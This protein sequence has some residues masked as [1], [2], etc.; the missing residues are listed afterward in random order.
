MESIRQNLERSN[1][2]VLLAKVAIQFPRVASFSLSVSISYLAVSEV[3]LID[4]VE[5]ENIDEIADE[6]ACSVEAI[7][8]LDSPSTWNAFN[9]PY[10]RGFDLDVSFTKLKALIENAKADKKPIEGIEVFNLLFPDVK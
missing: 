5:D 3:K 9:D 2:G 4:A 1:I 10:A 7:F 6:F 8:D